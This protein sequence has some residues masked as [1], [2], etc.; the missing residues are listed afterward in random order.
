LGNCEVALYLRDRE[1][2][3]SCPL[4]IATRP[5][6]SEVVWALEHKDK[7]AKIQAIYFSKRLRFP[8][9]LLQ[10]IL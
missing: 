9:D 4:K 3:M 2:W 8:D 6:C 1:T 5:H 7:N 10:Q